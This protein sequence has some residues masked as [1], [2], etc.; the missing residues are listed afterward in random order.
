MWLTSSSP[1]ATPVTVTVCGTIQSDRVNSNVPDT[2]ANL[3]LEM[4]GYVECTNVGN[5]CT[6]PDG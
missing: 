5:I 3:D 2:T 4:T 1:S 6:R